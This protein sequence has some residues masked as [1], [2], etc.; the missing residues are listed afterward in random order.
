MKCEQKWWRNQLI[1]VSSRFENTTGC[2]GTPQKTQPKYGKVEAILLVLFFWYDSG[3]Y[4]STFALRFSCTHKHIYSSRCGTLM[5]ACSHTLCAMCAFVLAGAH[6]HSR[7]KHSLTRI[8][9]HVSACT[10]LSVNFYLLYSFSSF[11]FRSFWHTALLY[12]A[13]NYIIVL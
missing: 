11:I 4:N 12:A 13:I 7:T 1:H 2:A 5:L 9:A 6:S 3:E 10:F 8:H